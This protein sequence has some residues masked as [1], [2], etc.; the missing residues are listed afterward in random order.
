MATG[1][2]PKFYEGLSIIATVGTGVVLAILAWASVRNSWLLWLAASV[3]GL[4]GLVHE[5]AQSGG[6]IVFFQKEKDG[7]YLGSLA[8]TVLGA[9][10]GLLV[11]RGHLTGSSPDV[12]TTQL[13]YEI[14]VA[15]LALKGVTEAAAGNPVRDNSTT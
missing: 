3:G 7:L 2:D 4:G 10:A 14:F 12:N 15:G 11:I 1:K 6:K 13:T 5:F 8:G 9:V